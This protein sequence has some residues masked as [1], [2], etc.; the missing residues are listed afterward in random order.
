MAK[1][2]VTLESGTADGVLAYSDSIFDTEMG[3]KSQKEINSD[4][5]KRIKDISGT[6]GGAEE[7]TT[8]W[9]EANLV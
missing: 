2:P 7:I 5:D 3:N 9:L 1:L 4:F 6:G 8:E